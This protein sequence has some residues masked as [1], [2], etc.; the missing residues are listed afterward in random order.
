MIRTNLSAAYQNHP[1]AGKPKWR[2]LNLGKSECGEILISFNVY[3]DK[4][5]VV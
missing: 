1:Y 4:E 2:K 5:E 3:K